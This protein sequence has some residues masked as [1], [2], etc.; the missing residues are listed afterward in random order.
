MQLA[1]QIL[2]VRG[3]GVPFEARAQ[4]MAVEGLWTEAL[5]A[6][7]AGLYPYISPEHDAVLANVLQGHPALRRP[8]MMTVADP[9]AAAKHYSA[10]LRWYY[11]HQYAK[12]ETEF[13]TAVEHD[14]QDARYHYYLGLSRL[15]QGDRS[16]AMEDFNQGARLEQQSRPPRAAVSAAL[17]RVQGEPRL[18][19]NE[20]RD[21]PR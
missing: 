21:R 13:F 18:Q 10:G 8:T 17:E 14:G 3:A 16:D 6:F 19:L 2:S 7:A 9:L 20:V 11:D 5:N 4:A 15:L 1:K 12:A